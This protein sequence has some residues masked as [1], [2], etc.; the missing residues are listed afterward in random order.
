[1]FGYQKLRHALAGQNG[2]SGVRTV[3]HAAAIGLVAP[4]ACAVIGSS[5]GGFTYAMIGFGIGLVAC[6]LTVE[7]LT[8]LSSD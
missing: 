3:G 7:L 6:V 5:I 1:M 2:S 4:V 8:V